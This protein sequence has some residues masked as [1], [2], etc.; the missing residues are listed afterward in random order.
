MKIDKNRR[1]LLKAATALGL[2]LGLC[3]SQITQAAVD[4]FIKIDGVDGESSDDHHHD[5][6]SAQIKGTKLI[7]RNAKG[8]TKVAKQGKYKLK[9]GRIIVVKNGRII[10]QTKG[11]LQAPSLHK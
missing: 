10:Q 2:S 9:D 4:A 1:T 11:R 6:I 5:W 7:L 3:T 8:Q